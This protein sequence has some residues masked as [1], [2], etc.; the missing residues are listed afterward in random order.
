MHALKLFG[1]RLKEKY[2]SYK[3]EIG[4]IAD[5]IIHRDFKADAPYNKLTTDIS[6]FHF[7]W[8]KCYL[9]S[10]LDMNSNKIV[11][12]VLSHSSNLEPINRMLAM[13]FA[14]I[15]IRK[16]SYSIVT[17]DGN[18]N[19]LISETNYQNEGLFNRCKEKVSVMIAVS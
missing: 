19:T 15:K 8:G 2:H 1:K 13:T 18:I 14:N 7:S 3:G 9:S 17:W 12:Y 6:Q 16:M 11:G 10:V 5:Y 4:K